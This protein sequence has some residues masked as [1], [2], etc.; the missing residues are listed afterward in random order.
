MVLQKDRRRF[1]LFLVLTLLWVAF[2]FSNSLK[3]PEESGQESGRVTEIVEPVV[4]A[5][6]GEDTV[7]THFLVRKA[8]HV[9]E[10]CLLGLC[11]LGLTRS[12]PL[13]CRDGCR[14]CGPF[15]ALF[16]GVIDEYIQSFTDRGSQ[17]Q[18]VLID[19][20]GALLGF[21]IG[22]AV[23]GLSKRRRAVKNAS[24]PSSFDQSGT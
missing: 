24:A 13:R 16:V 5:V 17:V 1:V 23:I 12:L 20:G 4:E 22:Y 3:G 15:A 18:D 14:A 9:I 7:D 21:A 11:L 19:F 8:G 10:F 2:I 6:F